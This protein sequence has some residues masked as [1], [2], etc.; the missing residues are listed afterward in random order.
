MALVPPFD[1]PHVMAGNGTAVLE[2]LRETG[3]LDVL[4][5]PVGGGGLLSGSLLAV[6]GLSPECVVYGVE[7]AAG[8]DT[9]RSLR[10]GH[11]VHIA[12][13]VTIADGAQ[14]QH[15]GTLTFPVIQRCPPADWCVSLTV[16]PADTSR[17]F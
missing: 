2:L 14:T 8:N 3:P 4:L 17:T 15:S 1:H 11:I 7:P 9:Q 6:Q 13:P 12:T 5:V 16:P 10:E